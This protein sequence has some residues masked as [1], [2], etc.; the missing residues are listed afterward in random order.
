MTLTPRQ[1]YPLYYALG[2]IFAWLDP[3]EPARA[4]NLASAIYGALAVGLVTWIADELV[5]SRWAGIAAGLFLAFSYTFWT[6]A[7]TAEVYTLHLVAVGASLLALLL[8]AKRPTRARLAL[9]YGIYALGFGNH[10]SMILLL[11]GFA[12]FILIHR[13]RGADDPLR[14]KMLIMAGA[15]AAAAALQYAWNFRGLWSEL[16]PPTTLAE[17]LSK[18]W[19][20]TTKADWRETL[21]MSVSA[22][23]LQNRPAMYWFDL[24]QQF[25]LPGIA[26]AALGMTYVICRWPRR[27]LLL[28]V[29]Y[30][31]NL[32]FGWTYNVGDVYIF[33]LPSHYVLAL[34]AGA[35]VSATVWLGSRLSH[36][37][38]ATTAGALC[39]LY[40]AWRGYDTFPAVDRS[41]DWR[42]MQLLD[43]FTSPPNA[44]F[45]FDANWQIQN[46]VEYYVR[47]HKPHVQWFTTEDLHGLTMGRVTERLTPLI[48]ANQRVSRQVLVSEGFLQRMFTLG[49]HGDADEI[50]SVAQAGRWSRTLAEEA[51][52]LR[53]GTRYALGILRPD[54]AYPFDFQGLHAA[55]PALTGGSTEI[56]RLG[57]YSIVVGEV[58]QSPLL[59][60]SRDRPYRVHTSMEGASF[61]IRMESWLPTD[62][63]RRAGFGHVIV[64]RKHVLTLERGLSFVALGP[65]SGAVLTTYRSSIF[66]PIPRYLLGIP[67]RR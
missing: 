55:W 67:A 39:L 38:I 27:G 46:A 49:Y 20:D 2:A 47:E 6:Q 16:D 50:Q 26:L 34:C 14:P 63:I 65:G 21:V 59:V 3:S 4:L 37:R 30:L 52:A 58:G 44:I 36:R 53:P 29:L 35:G 31:T 7:I 25:G 10:L 61:D 66:S 18:F 51:G 24:R 54:P 17:A 48:E 56:P 45:G 15:I 5:G 11:P 12:I 19:F 43:E 22:S 62:T 42:A 41:G 28:L 57:D 8:W 1:A 32:G 40:P 33:F 23:G 60:E 9:F 13:G 64:N